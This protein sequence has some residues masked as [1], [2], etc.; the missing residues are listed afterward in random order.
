MKSIPVDEGEEEQTL[1]PKNSKKTSKLDNLGVKRNTFSAKNQPKYNGR[2]KGDYSIVNAI[3]RLIDDP[4]R[5][6]KITG[7]KVPENL[8]GK[9]L[10]DAIAGKLLEQA[11]K[12]KEWAVKLAIDRLDGKSTENVNINGNISISDAK[13]VLGRV[14]KKTGKEKQ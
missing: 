11:F 10:M 12:G 6:E 7:I 13:S 14:V 5:F 3:K 2:K 9:E 1:L 8:E 4:A